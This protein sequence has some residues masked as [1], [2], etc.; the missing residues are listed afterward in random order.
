MIA[1]ALYAVAWA[2][3]W[4]FVRYGWDMAPCRAAARLAERVDRR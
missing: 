1:R 2:G 3:L 4:L